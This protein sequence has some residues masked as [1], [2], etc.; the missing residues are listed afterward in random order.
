MLFKDQFDQLNIVLKL[1]DE[2]L[3]NTHK[4][5]D[6]LFKEVLFILFMLIK[7]NLE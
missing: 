6:D 4:I 1:K 2:E 3:T 5:I 7:F